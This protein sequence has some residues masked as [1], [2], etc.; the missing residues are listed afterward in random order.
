MI[1]LL[2][3]EEPEMPL[4]L[5]HLGSLLFIF[6]FIWFLVLTLIKRPDLYFPK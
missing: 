2:W 3:L 1:Y 5:V 4:F 6:G